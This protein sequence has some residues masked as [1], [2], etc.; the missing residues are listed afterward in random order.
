[1]LVVMRPVVRLAAIGGGFE[2][3]G[4]RCGPLFPRKVALL[5]K[6]DGKG[7]RLSLPWLGKYRPAFIAREARQRGGSLGGG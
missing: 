2:L 1:M 5:G 6:L 4:E 3:F 7:K